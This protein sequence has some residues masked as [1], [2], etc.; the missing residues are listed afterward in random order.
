MAENGSVLSEK[1]LEYREEQELEEELLEEYLRDPRPFQLVVRRKPRLVVYFRLKPRT[2]YKPT[3]AQ[4][5]TR[6]AFA[7]AARKAKGI[8]YAGRGYGL[9]PAAEL[10]RREMT[11][12][13][14][15][16]KPRRPRWLIVLE[17]MFKTP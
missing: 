9:P 12:R 16:G 13:S 1:P 2:T 11:G 15:G 17:K 7:M 10:V 5:R 4:V 6:I 14:F 8:R 3:P